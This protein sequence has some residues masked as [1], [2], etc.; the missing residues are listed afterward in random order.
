[1]GKGSSSRLVF[2]T[3]LTGQ[4]PFSSLAD[5]VPLRP[6]SG[7]IGREQGYFH[8]YSAAQSSA[9][10]APPEMVGER[11]RDVRLEGE[12]GNPFEGGPFAG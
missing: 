7:A 5:C 4:R 10:L 6:D 12:S 8:L 2:M 1:M 9:L 11:R 3:P